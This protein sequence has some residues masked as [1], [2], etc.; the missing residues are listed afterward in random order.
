MVKDAGCDAWSGV[1]PECGGMAQDILCKST[2]LD[3]P[4]AE[5]EDCPTLLTPPASVRNLMGWTKEY[6]NEVLEHQ[7]SKSGS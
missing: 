4:V 5:C 7:K 6:V 3:Q 2:M 1:C